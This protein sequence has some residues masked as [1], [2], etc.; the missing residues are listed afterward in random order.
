MYALHKKTDVT[1]YKS[2]ITAV[3]KLLKQRAQDRQKSKSR[4]IKKVNKLRLIKIR[5]QSCFVANVSVAN[6]NFYHRGVYATHRV[7]ISLGLPK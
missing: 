1:L 5:D 4:E 7:N 6:A 3:K 2:F